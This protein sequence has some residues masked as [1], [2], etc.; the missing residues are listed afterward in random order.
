MFNNIKLYSNSSFK[1][2]R[3]LYWT[4]WTKKQ[5]KNL[6]FN[7]DKFSL[8]KKNVL[9][10]IHGDQKTW[11]LISCPYGK[12]FVVIL[13]NIKKSRS[14][15]KYMQ[16]ILSN[17]NNKSILI[18]PGYGLGFFC[19]SKECI[20]HYKLSYKGKYNDTKQQFTI[21]WNDPRH[22]IKWPKGK[23]ITSTRDT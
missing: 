17:K 5:N 20:F 23:K 13:N 9:R 8:S 22:K 11:K 4:S 14:Y 6:N 7:H 1:D 15:M 10:G 3:G 16:F 18:P 2:R 19:L 21:K 12:V